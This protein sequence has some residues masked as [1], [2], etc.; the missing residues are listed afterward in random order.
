MIYVLCG[1]KDSRRIIKELLEA[2]YEVIT[3]VVTKYGER[4]LRQLG[5]IEIIT[6]RLDKEEME[7]IINKYGITTVIDAT[8]PFAEEVSQNAIEATNNLDVQYV[9]FERE[10]VIL[11]D[12]ELI[13]KKLDFQSAIKHINKRSGKV[14]L[15]IGSKELPDFVEGISDFDQRVIVRILP[16]SQ[17]LKKCQKDLNIPIKNIIA[18]QGPFSRR[19]NKQILID[20]DIDLLVTKAS[21]KTG[22]LEAKLIAAQDLDIPTL[23]IERPKLDYIQV[24]SSL[25]ELTVYLAKL[26]KGVAG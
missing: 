18:M 24:V 8:H 5:D 15:T 1:T 16:T 3:S 6:G 22:G 9:R 11:P 21:G 14:L 10:G 4:L 19:L 13:I 12:N 23:V 20:Y 2:D 26:D 7:E 17:V 25:E